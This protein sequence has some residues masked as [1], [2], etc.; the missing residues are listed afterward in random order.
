MLPRNE[1]GV[2]DARLKV[3]GTVNV[4]VVDASVFPVSF[5]AHVSS[6]VVLYAIKIKLT[7]LALR[8][9]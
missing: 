2:V 8:Y 6:L 7:T 1:G 5:S 3:Y 4:R 9:R